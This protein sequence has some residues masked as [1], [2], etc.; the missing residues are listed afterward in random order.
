MSA[1]SVLSGLSL[2]FMTTPKLTTNSAN[3]N[4]NSNNNASNNTNSTTNSTLKGKIKGSKSRQQ[5]HDSSRSPSIRSL[6]S[7]SIT[8]N[9]NTNNI[10]NSTTNNNINTAKQRKSNQS[11]N[12]VIAVGT[13]FRFKPIQNC[14]SSI[15]NNNNNG[16]GGGDFKRNEF[17]TNYYD[18][19]QEMKQNSTA[20][21]SYGDTNGTVTVVGDGNDDDDDYFNT[22]NSNVMKNKFIAAAASAGSKDKNTN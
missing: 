22:I 6:S 2:N 11:G 21:L 9:N 8:V 10:N 5:Q 20:R 16:R 13:R 4:N 15:N 7:T 3:N 14:S 19:K 1:G 17:Y 18:W 12:A